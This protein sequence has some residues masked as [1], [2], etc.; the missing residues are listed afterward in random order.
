MVL[1]RSY[2]CMLL[3]SLYILSVPLQEVLF[4][5]CF[6]HVAHEVFSRRL[7]VTFK[8]FVFILILNVLREVFNFS[9]GMKY[10]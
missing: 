7:R 6:C 1:I 9:I 10:S 2:I 5:L 3:V 8:L 4:Y